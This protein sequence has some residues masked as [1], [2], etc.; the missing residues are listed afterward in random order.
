MKPNQNQHWRTRLKPK[1]QPALVLVTTGLAVAVQ[2]RPRAFV[3]A[4]KKLALILVALA[5]TGALVR[6]VGPGTRPLERLDWE[7][8]A[9]KGIR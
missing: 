2:K 4:V 6:E 7:P 3:A 1:R 5:G 9:E 8:R